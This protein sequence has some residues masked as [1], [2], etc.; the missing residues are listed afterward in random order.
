MR[1]TLD[2]SYGL[3]SEQEQALFQLLSVF[4]GGATLTA[5]EEVAARSGGVRPKMCSS[6]SRGS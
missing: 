6:C 3:L 5:V 4:R 2:W 1:A